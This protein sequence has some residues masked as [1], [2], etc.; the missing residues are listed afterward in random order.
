M[1][2][3]SEL[4]TQIEAVKRSMNVSATAESLR[5][6][7]TLHGRAA[8][9]HEAEA[10]RAREASKALQD[11]LNVLG[12]AGLGLFVAPPAKLDSP[13]L[14]L[15]QCAEIVLRDSEK[16]L[17][18]SEI[19]ALIHARGRTLGA[20]ATAAVTN[21]LK[22]HLGKEFYREE[23][24]GG[25]VYGLTEWVKLDDDAVEPRLGAKLDRSAEV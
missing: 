22:A 8:E 11:A 14:A 20:Q 16:P 10:G 7:I 13:A 23:A 15:W 4:Q 19:R 12:G 6:L 5:Q 9:L 18:A 24:R 3:L 21:A 1:T 17:S 25:I 2:T